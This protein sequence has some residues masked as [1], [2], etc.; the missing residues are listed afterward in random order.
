MPEDLLKFGMIPEFIGRLP[1]ITSVHNLDRE[2]L[3]QHPHRAAQRA[4]QAVPA[5]VR[6]RRRRAGVHRR[7]PRGD[8]R[9]GHPARHRRP[10]PA[11]D[12][13][14]GPAVGDVRGAEPRGRRPRRHHPRGRP[15]ATSTRRSSRARP[16]S[17]SAARSR[18]SRSP[19]HLVRADGLGADRSR[20]SRACR[21]ASSSA[22]RR[23]SSPMRASPSPRPDSIRSTRTAIVSTV[24]AIVNSSS[25]IRSTRSIARNSA[26]ARSTTSAITATVNTASAHHANATTAAP[27]L[28]GCRPRR[29]TDAGR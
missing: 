12:H 21:G 3:I 8:R 29:A 19:P 24:F 14:G 27:P 25:R 20:G 7:R 22:G 17:A 4:G 9:P 28:L 11:R 1:V 26:R 2:A 13:G 10:R 6:A 23:R 15:G 5:A 16:R 18:R